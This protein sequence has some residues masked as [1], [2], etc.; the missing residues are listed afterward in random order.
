MAVDSSEILRLWSELR[1][2]PSDARQF[3]ARR[4]S[5][6][7]AAE[8]YAAIRNS[9]GASAI[10]F[11]MDAAIAPPP[12]FRFQT[13][14]LAFFR[15][16]EP[17]NGWLLVGLVEECAQPSDLFAALAADIAQHVAG[18]TIA[19][20]G[21]RLTARLAQWQNALKARREGLSRESLIG[22][23]GELLVLAELSGR[24]D[25]QQAIAAWKG[26]E[27][28][29]HDFVAQ[30]VAVEV[31]CLAGIHT[32]VPIS[33][34]D[35][36][37]RRALRRLVLARVRLVEDPEGETLTSLVG[38]LRSGIG[39]GELERKLAMAG[40]HDQDS[41]RYEDFRFRLIGIDLFDVREGFPALTRALAP[42]GVSEA[43]YRIDARALAPFQL[44]DSALSEI[45]AEMAGRANGP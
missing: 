18:G 10:A 32:Q 5:S 11:R 40:W 26:P 37:D 29:V 13:E 19:G 34:L 12:R 3:R 20:A 36:L 6:S 33:S 42:E 4:A 44:G 2:E 35:Q 14:G 9:D 1:A 25:P 17:E 31:K 23:I 21:S 43:I 39:S 28:G 27:H 30:G 24:L 7:S 38:R 22:L 8:I 15:T 16:P 45:V 41:A